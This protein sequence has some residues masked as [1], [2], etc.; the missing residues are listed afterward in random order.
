MPD[1]VTSQSATKSINSDKIRS[2]SKLATNVNVISKTK[3]T[4]SK[5]SDQK[6]ES[7][8]LMLKVLDVLGNPVDTLVTFNGH[9]YNSNA[10]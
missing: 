1:I 4:T 8:G 5:G 2:V 9:S 7:A 6:S 3:L 10:R